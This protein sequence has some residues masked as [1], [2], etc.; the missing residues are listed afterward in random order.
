[1]EER[2]ANPNA[3]FE[4]KKGSSKHKTITPKPQGPPPPLKPQGPPVPEKI[5]KN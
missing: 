5:Q 4:A 3:V 2:E 1:M